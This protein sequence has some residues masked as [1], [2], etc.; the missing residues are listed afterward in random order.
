MSSFTYA[1]DLNGGSLMLR[2]SRVIAGL[3]L[4]G[5]TDEEWAQQIQIE[6]V[7]Q[8]R[9]PSTSKRFSAVIRTR[10]ALL[11]SEFWKAIRDGDDELAMQATFVSALQRNL[12]L[13]EFM[14]K[15][16]K[17]A[18]QLHAQNLASYQWL[19]FLD[20]CA[21]KDASIFD[22]KES[23]RKKMGTVVF[24]ML[25]EVGYLDNARNKN[26]QVMLVRPEIKGMLEN[27]FR[28]RLLASMDM[29]T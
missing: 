16:V 2:E 14:E 28:Q 20:D 19:D 5:A 12:L 18:Y 23:T 7:L 10:L 4:K 17:E 27:T 21:N 26:L 13:L 25:K 15:V 8:K 1:S 6:N 29:R 24:R 22:W 9:S 11:E 3:L